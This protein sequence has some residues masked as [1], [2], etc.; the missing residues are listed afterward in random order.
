M[1]Q[2]Y[3]VGDFDYLGDNLMFLYEYFGWLFGKKD[4]WWSEYFF[5][6]YYEFNMRRLLFDDVCV[7][8][9]LNFVIDKW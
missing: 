3:R 5:I 6:V 1:L 7:W 2:L 8:W 4:F 9:V